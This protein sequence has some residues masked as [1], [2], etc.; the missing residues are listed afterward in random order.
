[1]TINLTDSD[2]FTSAIAA[3]ADGDPANGTTFQVGLQGLANRTHYLNVRRASMDAALSGVG[4]TWANLAMSASLVSI[5][6]KFGLSGTV[7]GGDAA[8]TGGDTL[9]FSQ[10]GLYFLTAQAALQAGDTANPTR[11]GF[12]L[13][14]GGATVLAAEGDRLSANVN[15]YVF[16]TVS[17]LLAASAGTALSVKARFNPAGGTSVAN[18]SLI[19]FRIK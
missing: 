15:D 18:G 2:T 9:T 7:T 16:L 11:T 10:S 3:P 19:L 1:M 8:I 12:N 4:K 13:D 6:T 14:V 5:N 17:Y